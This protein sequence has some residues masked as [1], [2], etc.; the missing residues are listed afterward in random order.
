MRGTVVGC[1]SRLGALLALYT[2]NKGDR[3]E[4]ELTV[5]NGAKLI[6]MKT[7]AHVHLQFFEATA[8]DPAEDISAGGC[9]RCG[10]WKGRINT[11]IQRATFTG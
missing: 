9:R 7:S 3:G 1:E 6:L 10:R 8:A 2:K 4:P 11:R 5:G